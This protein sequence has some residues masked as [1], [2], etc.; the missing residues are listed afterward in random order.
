MTFNRVVQIEGTAQTIQYKNIADKTAVL[1]MCIYIES[2]KYL[3]TIDI[4]AE[5][6]RRLQLSA[7]NLENIKVKDVPDWVVQNIETSR[8]PDI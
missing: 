8:K 5:S 6:F 3:Q 7:K 2:S 1:V 4:P